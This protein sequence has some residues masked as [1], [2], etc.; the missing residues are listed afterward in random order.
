M[1]KLQRPIS[2]LFKQNHPFRNYANHSTSTVHVIHLDKILGVIYGNALGDAIGVATEFMDK[3]YIKEVF[4]DLS[5]KLIQ[6][7]N[8]D[9]V[10]DHSC[11]WKP[12][13]L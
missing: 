7:P 4:G 3:Q 11:Q 10:S 8:H 13:G 12:G 9:T 5:Q 6:F 1:H 2:S